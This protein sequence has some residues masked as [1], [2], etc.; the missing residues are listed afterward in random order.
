M[1]Q[2]YF[3]ERLPTVEDR[4]YDHLVLA[5]TG[6]F[7]LAEG[8]TQIVTDDRSIHSAVLGELKVSTYEVEVPD[9]PL[10]GPFL[11]IDGVYVDIEEATIERHGEQTA[12]MENLK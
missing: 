6:K 4:T 11:L 8:H 3:L 7:I 5:K 10:P 1:G 2:W 12:L 9:P